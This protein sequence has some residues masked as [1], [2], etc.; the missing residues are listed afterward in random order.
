[1]TRFWMVIRFGKVNEKTKQILKE[2][3][4]WFV[5]RRYVMQSTILRY[6]TTMEYFN[7]HCKL[8]LANIE[9]ATEM[10]YKISHRIDRK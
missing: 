10:I 3:L 4:E 7:L 5:I 8:M 1:M 9:H 6:S 2:E